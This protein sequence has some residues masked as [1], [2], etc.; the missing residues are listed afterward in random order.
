MVLSISFVFVAFVG[1]VKMSILSYPY[2][3]GYRRVKMLLKIPSPP[4]QEISHLPPCN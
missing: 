2:T 3:K 1:K 4:V